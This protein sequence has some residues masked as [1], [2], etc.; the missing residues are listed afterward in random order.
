MKDIVSVVPYI[1]TQAKWFVTD[2]HVKCIS[3][4]T[5]A[6]KG[7]YCKTHEYVLLFRL[8]IS[9]RSQGLWT[10]NYISDTLGTTGW[11]GG[12]SRRLTKHS[13]VTV[14]EIYTFSDSKE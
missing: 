13:H 8:N 2:L 9:E 7:V 1:R 6:E 5:S 12:A 3:G 4:N 10:V 14:M 11:A